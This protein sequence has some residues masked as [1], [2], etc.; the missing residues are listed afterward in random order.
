[1][2]S[3]FR[4]GLFAYWHEF[5]AG[6][7][8]EGLRALA[9]YFLCAMVL[10]A[11]VVVV[12]ATWTR[13]D[14]ISVRV[15]VG[16]IALGAGVIAVLVFFG[17]DLFLRMTTSAIALASISILAIAVIFAWSSWRSR[18]LVGLP[19]VWLGLVALVGIAGF[20]LSGQE[21]KPWVRAFSLVGLAIAGLLII[22][23]GRNERVSE[24]ERAA[25]TAFLQLQDIESTRKAANRTGSPTMSEVPPAAYPLLKGLCVLGDADDTAE[26]GDCDSIKPPAGSDPSSLSCLPGW[27][28][29]AFAQWAAGASID[30]EVAALA[31]LARCELDAFDPGSLEA[32]PNE[33]Q[34]DLS[35]SF[36]AA[37]STGSEESAT[38]TE[39]AA[40]EETETQAA[41]DTETETQAASDARA[42][43]S[44]AL[45]VQRTEANLVETLDR[46]ADGVLASISGPNEFA[47][48]RFSGITWLVLLG[49]ALLWYRLLEIRAGSHGL[50]PVDISFDDDGSPSSNKS[51]GEQATKSSPN[52]E[53]GVRAGQ[54]IFKQAVVQNVPEPGAVPGAHA[55]APVGDLVSSSDVPNKFLASGLIDALRT[56]LA[57]RSGYTVLYSAHY[58]TEMEFSDQGRSTAVVFVRIRD[59]R[60]GSQKASMRFEADYVAEASQLAG[61]WVAGWI[62]SRSRYVPEWAKWSE[63]DAQSFYKLQWR[64]GDDLPLKAHGV[65]DPSS[66]ATSINALVLTQ[67]AYSYEIDPRRKLPA[68]Y[69]ALEDFARAA[70]HQPRYPVARFRTAVA[71]SALMQD[72]LRLDDVFDSFEEDP[73]PSKTR[74]LHL[75]QDLLELDVDT[76]LDAWIGQASKT[77]EFDPEMRIKMLNYVEVLV[78]RGRIGIR[79]GVLARIRPSERSFWKYFSGTQKDWTALVGVSGA[80]AGLRL[81]QDSEPASRPMLF[82]GLEDRV[83]R[84]EDRAIEP[85]SHWQI[86]YNIA[87]YYSLLSAISPDP[88]GAAAS[89]D[90]ESHSQKSFNWLERCLDRPNNGQLVREWAERDPDLLHLRTVDEA[91][92]RRWVKRVP[93]LP[94]QIR[95]G[96]KS[97]QVRHLQ[98]R[99]ND[100]RDRS[101]KGWDHLEADGLFGAKTVEAVKCMQYNSDVRVTGTP[102]L[103]LLSLLE[104]SPGEDDRGADV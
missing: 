23:I 27:T 104:A 30:R 39:A 65:V 94:I 66:I 32:N 96:D 93:K 73:R 38:E 40:D 88:E 36:G 79:A 19:A 49:L 17:S 59:S 82:K 69:N 1:V 63:R 75:F 101:I 9:T 55:L 16:L 80:I 54:A 34:V 58:E 46:G 91:E 43:V 99:L 31:A 60:N 4:V 62:V 61:Y 10:I 8:R 14:V 85:E 33:S 35:E 50:G 41:I 25:R 13:T 77:G 76:Q 12:A 15:S 47:Q 2:N 42:A 72:G 56:I 20:L 87:C 53:D 86:S 90:G 22:T 45:A 29:D 68:T 78:Q 11:G 74:L 81:A 70:Y 84:F 48:F 100:V 5:S 71:L 24:A 37:G 89:G 103:Y 64:Q 18:W 98:E 44:E 52:V 57:T 21:G 95:P 51:S 26:G 67:R 7:G 102:D 28:N 92:W 6:L 83:K 3:E 97:S